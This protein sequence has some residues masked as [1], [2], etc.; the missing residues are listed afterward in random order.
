MPRRHKNAAERDEHKWS[1]EYIRTLMRKLK[2]GKV[3]P[4][5]DI[6]KVEKDKRK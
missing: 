4:A 2:E 5:Y 3:E 6:P 1:D